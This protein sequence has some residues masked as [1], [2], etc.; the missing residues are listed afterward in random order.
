MSPE[1][2]KTEL[3]ASLSESQ[4]TMLRL[5]ASVIV[6]AWQV[7]RGTLTDYQVELLRIM[8]E[9]KRVSETIKEVEKLL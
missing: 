2:A 5:L 6:R 1:E 8:G 3:L 9:D 4:I 7:M